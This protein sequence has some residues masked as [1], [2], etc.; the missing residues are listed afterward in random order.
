M[1]LGWFRSVGVYLFTLSGG[2]AIPRTID[3]RP[4]GEGMMFV[5]KGRFVRK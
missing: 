2:A 1:Y 3:D 5:R 4:Y